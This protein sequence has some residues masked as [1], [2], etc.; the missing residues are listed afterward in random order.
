[1]DLRSDLMRPK[2]YLGRTAARVELA[3]THIS[4]VFLL[5]GDVFKVKRPVDFGFL[6]FR[7]LE[8]RKHACEAEITLNRRLAPD[9]YLGVVPV[10]IGRD[11]CA[12]IGG[13]GEIVDWAV[14][15]RRLPE[16]ARADVRLARGELRAEDI[17]VIAARL[18]EFHASARADEH[19]AKFGERETIR[20][21]VEENFAQ[22]AASITE[23]VT[24]EE[25]HE[26]ASW[27]AAFV[28]DHASLFDARIRAG[29]VRDGHGDLRLEHVYLTEGGPIVIDCIEF[30]ERFRFA[31]VCAD[32][33]F[34][35]MDLAASNRVDLAER[36]L[37]AY[38]RA[39]NDFDLYAVADFYESYRAFIRAKVSA[40]IASDETIAQ[41][42]RDRARVDARK[43]FLLSL[44]ADRA[45]FLE[46]MLVVVGGIIASGKSTIADHVGA[47]ASAPVIDADRTRKSMVGVR[48]EQPIHDGAW[49][50]AYDPAFTEHV[51][52]EVFR[53]A[54]VVLAS[55]RP[56]V[57]DASFR[58]ARLRA[59]ARELAERYEVPFHF[60]ECRA[61]RAT[62]RARLVERQKNASVSDGRLAIF[63]DFC[64]RY[65]AP[66]ELESSELL[67]VDTSQPMETTLQTLTRHL[68]T[69]PRGF[70]A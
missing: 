33:A 24:Y 12:C 44:S 30:N 49:S 19:T 58:S 7:S 10:R 21:N 14:H 15:M 5:D 40:M 23:H 52:D 22:T 9:V 68:E 2:A 53:R 25:A 66:S 20:A 47:A 43:Y 45:P 65:E 3:E 4:W 8:S 39:S 41:T 36:L 57:L 11:G 55:G 61:D 54:E 17:D 69:W 60:V 26:I 50:G 42:T 64:A 48:A 37:A 31:D 28:E 32:V 13:D 46:P 27:Q 6:D 38:A 70:V 67:A 56:V 35:S 1:M 63:D 62:C 18:A 51:Y 29:R 34:L 59:K 16:E